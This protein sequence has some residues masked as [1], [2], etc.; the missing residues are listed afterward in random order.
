MAEKVL[1]DTEPTMPPESSAQ[2]VKTTS[3]CFCAKKPLL[4][5]LSIVVL[6]FLSSL[7]TYLLVKSQTKSQAPISSP[8]TTQ[9]SSTQPS[10]VIPSPTSPTDPTA[11]WKEYKRDSY[12][13]SFRYPEGVILEDKSTGDITQVILA[14]QEF[15]ETIIS[16]RKDK[17]SIY[18]LD[19]P[20]FGEVVFGTLTGKKYFLPEGYCDG[21]SCS[22][23]I[24][25]AV[26]YNKGFRYVF[27]VF[28]EKNSNSFTDLENQIL[29]TFKILD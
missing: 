24:L 2:S 8:S 5:I 14:A 17:Q 3:C 28:V 12:N 11:G 27:S 20:P 15:R 9:P 13:F 19:T 10:T 6:V 16:A 26:V 18:Y 21:P 1:P 23:P 25:A 29:S 7:V 22:S 4:M